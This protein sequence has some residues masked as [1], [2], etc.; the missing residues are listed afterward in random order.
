MEYINTKEREVVFD[1]DR[2]K[3]VLSQVEKRKEN[4]ASGNVQVPDV[5]RLD[6]PAESSR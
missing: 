4:Y 3:S 2:F 5:F 1:T 6:S